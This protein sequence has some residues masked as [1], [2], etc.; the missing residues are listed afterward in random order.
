VRKEVDAQIKEMM[1]L[2]ERTRGQMGATVFNDSD[3][4]MAGY[5]A[6]LKV[7][8][9]Y[10]EINGEDVTRLALRPRRKGEKTVVDDIVQQAAETAS[11]LLIPEGLPKA[12]W[13]VIGGIQ[14]F[15]L[16]ML[17]METETAKLDDYQNFA[18][19]FRV[20]N[21]QAVMASLKPNGARLKG[22]QDF[23]PRE[24]A[25][26]EIGKTWL[27]QVLIALQE[28]L[29]EKEPPVVMD[30]LRDA[31]SDY[32]QQRQHLQAIAQFLHDKLVKRRPEEARAAEIIANRVQTERL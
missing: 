6:A 30:N 7:L 17:D 10:T 27:G 19:A 2:N 12:T 8:T 22:A 5:A 21:Y 23:K 18:K 31:L 20:E 15:Y 4:Q 28:L 25:G 16:R 24:L 11:N 32:F 3:L 29:K 14:R 13:E 26:T 1:H 9:G